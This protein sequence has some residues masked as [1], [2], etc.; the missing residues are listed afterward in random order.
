MVR[1][2]PRTRALRIT[3][4]AIS[5]ILVGETVLIFLQAARG[6]ASHRRIPHFL[7]MHA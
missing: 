7:G 2:L 3:M 4:W 6:T 1:A 5:G